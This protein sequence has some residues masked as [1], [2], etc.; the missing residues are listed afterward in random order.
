MIY[1]DG[2]TLDTLG[3]K[4]E[5]PIF[6]TL[7]NIP[8]LHCNLPDAKVF[9]GFLPH[10]TTRDNK[11]RN[12]KEFKQ[13]QRDLKHRALKYLLGPL[14]KEDGIYLAVNGKVEHF[15]IYLSSIIADM[16]EAQDICCTYKS[17]RTR[18]PCYKC[19]MPGDQL[20]NMNIK[21]DMIDLRNHENMQ[22]AIASHNAEN[23]SI[24]EYD[25]FFWNFRI[26]N[27]Y[28]AA[29]LD[30]MH[31]QEIGLFPYMLDYTRGMLM[32]QYGKQI[33]SKMDNRLATITRFNNLRILKK[34]YQ[35]G[36]KFTGDSNLY[37]IAS[38]K[39]LIICYIKFIKMYITSRK[40][41][42]NEDDLKIFEREIID[43]SNDFVNIFAQFSSSGL[44]LPKLHMWRYHTIHTIRRYGALNGLTT[45]TYKTL[46]KNW[47]KN[48]Y[49]MSNKKN[50]HNQ[51]LKTIRRQIITNTITKK[52][53]SLKLNS[54]KSLLWELPISEI[55]T[56]QEKLKHEEN[57]NELCIEGME[58][59]I[60]CLDIYLD[61]ISN[62]SANEEIYLKIYANGTL[63]NGEIVYATSKFHGYARFSDVAIAMGDT[64]YLTDGGLCYGKA[65]I[66]VN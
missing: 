31:L 20:N 42:F 61:D 1:I 27:I 66:N 62:A 34:G 39:N 45:E 65:S 53:I 4:S 56:F 57:I 3:R 55:Y 19:L 12:S 22:E 37:T 28:D 6:L 21:Q 40:K 50:T 43:W 8:N 2:T 46:H 16:L 15:T 9:I 59:L 32:H 17:Y 35:Q 29:A 51:M 38:C 5:Y 14:L 24:H 54:M 49:R 23:Y 63:S 41:K 52:T 13:K 18:C 33:I 64:D 26:M 11:L 60:A 47:I 30:H 10:L 48:P 7:G 44:Q 25:N 36:T 58:H